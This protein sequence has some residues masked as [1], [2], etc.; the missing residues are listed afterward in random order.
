MIRVFEATAYDK[1]TKDWSYETYLVSGLTDTDNLVWVNDQL[2][3]Y[4]ITDEDVHYYFED[5][6]LD[7]RTFKDTDEFFYLLG[8][9]IT[10][11]DNYGL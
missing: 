5:G 11:G 4:G 2:K 3:P 10:K 6:A 9:E 1:C 8:E 7:G